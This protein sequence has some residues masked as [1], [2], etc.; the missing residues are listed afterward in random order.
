MRGMQHA[1]EKKTHTVFWWEYLNA[2]NVL[3]DPSVHD[4]WSKGK[5]KGRCELDSSGSRHEPLADLCEYGD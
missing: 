4:K 5:R 2:R 3:E 1:W